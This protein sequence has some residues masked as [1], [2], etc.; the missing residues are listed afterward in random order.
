M[1][2][3]DRLFDK[4]ADTHFKHIR[5]FSADAL[6][7]QLRTYRHYFGKLLPNELGAHILEIGCGYGI[8]LQF[9]RAEGYQNIE[10]VDICPQQVDAARQLGIANIVCRD[11]TD[12]LLEK[13]ESYD[14][15][16][17]IDFLDHLLKNQIIDL[18]EAIYR[19][20]RPGGKVIIQATNADGPFA[21]RLRYGDFT[22][23][24]ALTG[25][26]AS[27]LLRATG[28]GEIRI[29]GT[30]PYIHG[31]LSLI[32]VVAWRAI[33]ALFWVFVVAETGVTRG[34]IFTQ[35]LI[36]VAQKPTH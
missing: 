3:R 30:D 21:G 13:P 15:V 24:F 33:K 34:Y 28:F 14:C 10:G 16:I 36:A 19:G 6:K 11:A 2:Y 5:E 29:F 4:Y 32:R 1:G 18:L 7:R 8:F 9:L 22:H 26:S 35:N 23:E 20:L 31:F 27:Q 25:T 17:A 12:F